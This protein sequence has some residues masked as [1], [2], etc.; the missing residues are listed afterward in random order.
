MAYPRRLVLVFALISVVSLGA[1][2][3]SN[4][5]IDAV[6]AEETASLGSAAYVALVAGD[7]VDDDSTPQKAVEV[8]VAAGWL[9]ADADPS[10]PAG[11]GQ[12]AYLLMQVFEV[13]G[14]LLYRIFP[15]PRYA[16][17]EFTYQGW[18]PLRV[19]PGDRFSGEY[20]LSVAGIFLEDLNGTFEGAS[21]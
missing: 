16:T 13:N 3:Q 14:G 17:R 15:G 9:D 2:A 7:L 11:F 19:G 21:E 20:L 6:L 4:D 12:F 18:S 8:A 5:T 1:A 10:A